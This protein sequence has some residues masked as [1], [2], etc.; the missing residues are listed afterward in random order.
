MSAPRHKVGNSKSVHGLITH[1]RLS[2][3]SHNCLHQAHDVPSKLH[4]LCWRSQPFNCPT[5]D[6]TSHESRSLSMQVVSVR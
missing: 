1:A 6:S 2:A 5:P 3:P 4:S